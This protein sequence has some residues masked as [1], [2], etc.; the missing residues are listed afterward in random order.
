VVQSNFDKGPEGWSSYDY[1]WSIVAKGENIFVLT[2]WK[3]TGGVD[4]G[5][6]VWADETR[7]S[8]DT[9][10]SP[11][12]VL[13]MMINRNW[14][15]DGP[16]DVREAKVSAHL[17]GDGFQLNGARCYFWIGK[18]G[19]RWHMSG[20]PLTISEGEW[21]SES[22][23]ITLHNDEAQWYRSWD[24]DPAGPASLDDVLANATSYGFSFVGFGQEPRGKL[25][26]SKF[27]IVLP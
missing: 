16:F 26:L 17:R 8:A 5:G 24:N 3:P 12:S 27:E 20:S 19:T 23:T 7:W 1:H 9:P 22:N 15:G 2:T 14:T 10:E 4:G 13:P 11:V 18:P 25:S 21:A 6:Y